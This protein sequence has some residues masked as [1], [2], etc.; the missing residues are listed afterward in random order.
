M[1]VEAIRSEVVVCVVSVDS[2]NFGNLHTQ[3]ETYD[4][5]SVARLMA[6]KRA[7]RMFGE[8]WP[9]MTRGVFLRR[10]DGTWETIAN[11]FDV[12][13]RRSNGQV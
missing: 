13:A 10:T 6:G 11:Y 12:E 3:I 5:E 2:Y 9:S 8:G 7:N 4:T 1:T